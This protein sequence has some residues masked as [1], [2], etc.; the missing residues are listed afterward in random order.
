MAARPPRFA[1]ITPLSDTYRVDVPGRGGLA[2]QGNILHHECT[3]EEDHRPVA[4]ISKRWFR[5]RDTF[6][7]VLVPGTIDPLR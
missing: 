3:I 1:L 4:P 7:V 5:I 6:G 2:T